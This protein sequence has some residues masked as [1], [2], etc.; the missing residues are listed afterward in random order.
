MGANA[1]TSVPVYASGEVLTAASLNAN[2]TFAAA[3][4]TS[5]IAQVV[6]FTSATQTSSTSTSFVTSGIAA[7]ITFHQRASG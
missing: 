3:N 4:P 7:T 6:N 2:F 5:K 1:T